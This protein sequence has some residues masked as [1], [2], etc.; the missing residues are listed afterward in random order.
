MRRTATRQQPTTQ[1]TEKGISTI[2]NRLIY[3]SL[4]FGRAFLRYVKQPIRLL[5]IFYP[6]T[7]K[8][9]GL[10]AFDCAELAITRPRES[11]AHSSSS[12]R[13]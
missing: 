2:E 10:S 7:R 4:G 9:V 12:Y 1:H 5:A 13:A 11:I 3:R 8:Q 6:F